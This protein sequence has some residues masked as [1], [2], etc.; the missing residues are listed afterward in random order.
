MSTTV[1]TCTCCG[2][3]LTQQQWQGLRYVGRILDD[4]QILE[5]RDCDTCR[6]TLAIA[7]SLKRENGTPCE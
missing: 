2:K 4:S 7:V 6:S 1:K 3:P 5:L